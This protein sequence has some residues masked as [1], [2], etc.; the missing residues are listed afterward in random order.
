VKLSIISKGLQ[1]LILKR[2]I[3]K[4]MEKCKSCV[5]VVV[6][7]ASGVGGGTTTT[8]REKKGLQLMLWCALANNYATSKQDG[9]L[10]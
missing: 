1:H 3:P 2:N 9:G 5:K 4:G 6:A 7:R 10:K 8:R